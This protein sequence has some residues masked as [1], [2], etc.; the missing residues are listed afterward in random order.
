VSRQPLAAAAAAVA[1]CR[2]TLA[3]VAFPGAEGYGANSTGGRGGDVYH[4]TNL[5]DTGAG[6]LRNG[7][8]TRRPP[9]A[10]S[11]RRL[12]HD[13]ID[14]NVDDRQVE[15]HDC[16]QTAPGLG[17]TLKDYTFNVSSSST[18]SNVVVRHIRAERA[19]P[20]LRKTRWACWE[21]AA[22]RT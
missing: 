19:T 21:A 22:C 11:S 12:W 3:V 2:Q 9:G 7:S 13:R 15:H 1:L 5:L 20:T 6:S 4:V 8:Q 10:R 18:I 14:D 17:I 16:G